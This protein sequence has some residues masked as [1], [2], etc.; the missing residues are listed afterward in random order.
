MVRRAAVQSEFASLQLEISG[1]I[2]NPNGKSGVLLNGK[3]YMVG[4]SISD[5]LSVK[6]ID[7][8]KIEF[9][10]KGQTFARPW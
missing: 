8:S 2:H 5:V 6:L 3:T 4:D 9:D 7:R 1:V 10:Y